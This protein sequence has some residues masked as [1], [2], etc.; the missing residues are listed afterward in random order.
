M[1]NMKIRVAV[2]TLVA[3]AALIA[4]PAGQ[5]LNVHFRRQQ[6]ETC[7]VP[8]SAAEVLLDLDTPED[9]QSLLKRSRRR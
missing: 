5:G 7:E 3:V 6:G 8:V 9:Y 4:L 2:G 1:R